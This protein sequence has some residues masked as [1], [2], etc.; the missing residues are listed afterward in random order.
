MDKEIVYKGFVEIYS[1]NSETKSWVKRKI[2]NP[3]KRKFVILFCL[4][5]CAENPRLGSY[6]KEESLSLL[7]EP[8][9]KILLHPVYKLNKHYDFKGKRFVLEINNEKE[10]WYFS[11]DKRENVDLWATQIQMQ[12]K[13]GRLVSTCVYPVVGAAT[14]DMEH[15]GASQQKCLLHLNKWGITLALLACRSIL[16]M[17]PLKTIRNYECGDHRQFQIEA[18]RRAPMGEGH[19]VFH[20]LVGQEDEIFKMLDGFIVSAL[21]K[22]ASHPHNDND[23]EVQGPSIEADNLSYGIPSHRFLA[24]NN[25]QQKNHR[26]DSPQLAPKKPPLFPSNSSNTNRNIQST[27]TVTPREL[28]AAKNSDLPEYNYISEQQLPEYDYISDQ[29]SGDVTSPS[30]NI[31]SSDYNYVENDLNVQAE[32]NKDE[33]DK[34]DILEHSI[35]SSSPSNYDN[36]ADNRVSV[37]ATKYAQLNESSTS[38]IERSVEPESYQVPENI[39]CYQVPENIP[40]YQVPENI[41]CYQVPENTPCYQVPENI[42]CHQVPQVENVIDLNTNVELGDCS[43]SETEVD[44]LSAIQYINPLYKTDVNGCSANIV[45]EEIRKEKTKSTLTIKHS[46]QEIADHFIYQVPSSLPSPNDIDKSETSF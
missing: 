27:N 35:S 25:I 37:N 12:S 14:E 32:S 26:H 29:K 9:T 41:P 40:C 44:D 6:D 19:F 20:T 21:H 10:Q 7:G 34:Y 16:A 33:L 30:S 8:K 17:W 42:P 5:S 23:G 18:G 46:M 13:L 43:S 15:I 4:P 31:K 45:C 2:T 3:W 38:D 24:T 11:S 39:P 36:I 1:N 22:K 28:L